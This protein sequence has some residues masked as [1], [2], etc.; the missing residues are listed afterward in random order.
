MR[1]HGSAHAAPLGFV[2][3]CLLKEQFLQQRCSRQPS[4]PSPSV[5]PSGTCTPRGAVLQERGAAHRRT[6]LFAPVG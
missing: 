3:C 5:S 1:S 2:P 6:G 4:S